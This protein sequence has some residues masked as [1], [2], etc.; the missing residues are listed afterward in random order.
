MT[1]EE[2]VNWREALLC[3]SDQYFFDLIRMYLG[4]V[5]T[6][7]NK[8]RLIEELSGFLRKKSNK[9]KIILCLDDFDRMVLAAVSELPSPTQQ[10][11]VSLFSGTWAFPELYER[12]LNLEERLIIYRQNDSEGREY[13]INP[14]L[15]DELLPLLGVSVLGEPSVRDEPVSAPVRI[16]DLSLA[17]L[18]SFFLHEGEAV[19]NDGSP[20]KK[21]IAS[22]ETA[23][24]QLAA[25]EDCLRLLLTAFQNL[26]LLVKMQGCL[27]PDPSRWQLFAECAPA[28][29]IA[30]LVA[31]AGGRFQRDS[32][33]QRAQNFLDFFAAI[34]PGARYTKETISRL[35]FLLAEK[36]GRPEAGRL[37]GRFA[38]MM[39]EQNSD[40][41]DSAKA[42][43]TD[44]A[45]VSFAFG[46]LLETEGFLVRN[47]ALSAQPAGS[48]ANPWLVVSPSFSV[49]LMPGFSLA[50]LLPLVG[51]MEVR[52]IQIAGQF[53]ITRKSC[54]SAFE[55]GGTAETVISLF[56]GKSMQPIPQN[57]LFSIENWYRNYSSVSLY[58]GYVL[59]VDESRR[60]LFENNEHLSSLIRRVLSPG[61]YL[62]D[63]DSIEDIQE[64]FSLANIDTLPSINTPSPKRDPVPLPSLR[65]PVEGFTS[66][67]KSG[68]V[69]KTS[70]AERFFDEKKVSA[71]AELHRDL[72]DALEEMQLAPDLMDSL[73]SR[74]ERR[75]VINSSQ[76]DPESVRIEKVE[77]RGMDFLGKVRIAEYAIVSGSLLEITLDDKDGNRIILGRPVSTEKHPGDVF[78]KI[79]TEPDHQTEQISLGKAVVVRR[80]RGSIF[81][82]L[83]AGRP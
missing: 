82:E 55:Q 38:A 45:S 26:G 70:A 39:N 4:A 27:V 76:L 60:V 29:R 79:V 50:E 77:A 75:I 72:I 73:K 21:T 35:S 46:C 57:V 56:R 37:H 24:P 81:M 18:Y 40:I 71:V 59:R 51:C 66:T 17:A 63:A 42:E 20:R 41:E 34:E 1:A 19:K 23:F 28:E 33:Q 16:D 64:A 69:E 3:L 47:S 43:G 62:L 2:V 12:I 13:A 36:A 10:K 5:K 65:I 67:L 14:L 49:T 53:E 7:F 6:P 83:P 48:A 9:D 52:D 31:S 44:F 78:L 22:L 32:L 25:R 68:S 8:Q 80:I 30:W 11:I 61:I 54:S 15:K 58:H 74:I